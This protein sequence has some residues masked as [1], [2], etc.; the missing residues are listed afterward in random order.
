MSPVNRITKIFLTIWLPVF[1]GTLLMD[2][3][4]IC[5]YDEWFCFYTHFVRPRSCILLGRP[6]HNI[7]PVLQIVSQT[8]RRQF[9]KF[10]RQL[11]LGLSGGGSMWKHITLCYM[12]RGRQNQVEQHDEYASVLLEHFGIV[13]Y[14]QIFSEL[15]SHHKIM[16]GDYY[17]CLVNTN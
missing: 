9:L 14:Y 1:R 12:V 8:E 11:C 7:F 16:P 4:E 5:L 6:I 2:L 13:L 10:Q 17:Q 15:Y 3:I